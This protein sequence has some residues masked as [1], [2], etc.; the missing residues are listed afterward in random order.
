MVRARKLKLRQNV[1]R[2]ERFKSKTDLKVRVK[3][4]AKPLNSSK[5]KVIQLETDIF[6]VDSLP[7]V[8]YWAGKILQRGSPIDNR[9]S[10][11]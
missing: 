4:Q 1:P 10:I 9:P 7:I 8:H 2:L 11:E 3:V 5:P 6:T